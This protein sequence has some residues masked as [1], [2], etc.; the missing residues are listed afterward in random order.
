MTDISMTFRGVLQVRG[1][2]S[3]V[4]TLGVYFSVL[5]QHNL[6]MSHM[7]LSIVQ[8]IAWINLSKMETTEGSSYVNTW[9]EFWVCNKL[10]SSCI[11][12]TFW[13]C[14]YVSLFLFPVMFPLEANMMELVFS[15]RVNVCMDLF[16][17]RGLVISCMFFVPLVS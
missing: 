14:E 1:R 17:K 6:S 7:P 2:H 10:I 13:V 4:H 12:E 5:L 11:L 9:D 16:S 3:C 8:V 15:E